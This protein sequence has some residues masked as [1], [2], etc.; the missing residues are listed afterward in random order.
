M[1]NFKLDAYGFQT[2]WGRIVFENLNQT[3]GA[4]NGMLRFTFQVHALK[5]TL[6]SFSNQIILPQCAHA[7]SFVPFRISNLLQYFF[8]HFKPFP[9]YKIQIIRKQFVETPHCRI[10]RCIF[11]AF[12]NIY[13]YLSIWHLIQFDFMRIFHL[14]WICTCTSER[15]GT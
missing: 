5:K 14:R 11:H 4:Q 15:L 6:R 2:H 1:H 10:S 13:S 12:L 9:I 3:F 7:F 8:F